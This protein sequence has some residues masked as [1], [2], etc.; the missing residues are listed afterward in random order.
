MDEKF[1]LHGL[2]RSIR[3]AVKL[4]SEVMMWTAFWSRF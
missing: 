3:N 2:K 4:E 1:S